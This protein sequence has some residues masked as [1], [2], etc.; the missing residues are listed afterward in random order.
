MK[1]IIFSFMIIGS[2]F[3]SFAFAEFTRDTTNEVVNDSIS[4]LMWQD[5]SNVTLTDYSSAMTK[6]NDL[7]L[8][9]Y[10]DWRLPN[11]NELLSILDF[12]GTTSLLNSAFVNARD[13]QFWSSTQLV[14]DTTKAWYVDFSNNM[15]KAVKSTI[16]KNQSDPTLMP[17]V[18]CVRNR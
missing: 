8:A 3:C 15:S 18:R 9:T 2:F 11:I 12:T 7:V 4:A 13:K 10:D 17:Y 5:D 16:E 6:C 1:N 14:S